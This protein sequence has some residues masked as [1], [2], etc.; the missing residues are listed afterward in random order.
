V[1]LGAVHFVMIRKGWQLEPVI[2]LG[3]ALGLIAMRISWKRRQ[4][5][6]VNAR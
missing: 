3:L 6:A 1:V 4:S 5:A 2:Y